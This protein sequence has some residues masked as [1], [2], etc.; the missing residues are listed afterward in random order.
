MHVCDS[1]AAVVSHLTHTLIYI[2]LKDGN[3]ASVEAELC[4]RCKDKLVEMERTAREHA[5]L[6]SHKQF[7]EQMMQMPKKPIR[8]IS[9]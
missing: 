1:C 8:K 3:W 5:I 6:M 9:A 7:M 2:G 4:L